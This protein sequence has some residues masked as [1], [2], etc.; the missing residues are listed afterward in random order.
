MNNFYHKVAVASV[1]IALGFALGTHKEAKA[2]TFTFTETSKYYLRNQG[3]LPG[4]D[5]IGESL[6]VGIIILIIGLERI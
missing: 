6:P 4:R 3:E 5:Y 1:G 2:A